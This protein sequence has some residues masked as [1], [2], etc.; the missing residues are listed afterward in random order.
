MSPQAAVILSTSSNSRQLRQ[1]K[2]SRAATA[3]QP[4]QTS[5]IVLSLKGSRI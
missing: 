1:Q 3:K 2:D 4:M 5:I